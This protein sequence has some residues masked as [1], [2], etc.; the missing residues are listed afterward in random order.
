MAVMTH[1]KILF[2]RLIVT[3]IFGVLVCEP[4]RA[5]QTTEKAGPDRVKA[6]LQDEI[7]SNNLV[8]PTCSDSFVS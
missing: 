4:P 8:R 6:N 1:V 3:L 7:Y 2:N 5:R